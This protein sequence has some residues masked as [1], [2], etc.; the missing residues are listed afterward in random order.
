[1]PLTFTQSSFQLTPVPPS[2]RG[3]LTLFAK[4]FS[5]SSFQVSFFRNPSI[6][7]A[8]PSLSQANPQKITLDFLSKRCH[9]LFENIT[10][11]KR[12]PFGTF[13][14]PFENPIVTFRNPFDLLRGNPESK[15][16][17]CSISYSLKVRFR[18]LLCR[19][20]ITCDEIISQTPTAYRSVKLDND[21]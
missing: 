20:L 19:F 3:F 21:Q 17:I 2:K 18:G 8:S 9:H 5:T 11:D 16:T 14:P 6:S 12:N 10:I 7:S 15:G 1:M 13:S 4:P